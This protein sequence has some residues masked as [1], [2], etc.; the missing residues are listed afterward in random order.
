MALQ[1]N[2]QVGRE[3]ASILN[4]DALVLV[5]NVAIRSNHGCK[6]I[7]FLARVESATLMEEYQL[8]SLVTRHKF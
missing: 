5:T 3:M 6:A 1:V 2:G 8:T 7:Q 4:M